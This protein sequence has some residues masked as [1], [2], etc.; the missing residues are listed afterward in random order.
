MPTCKL[1]TAPSL[2]FHVPSVHKSHFQEPLCLYLSLDFSTHNRILFIRYKNIFFRETKITVT[3]NLSR[4][5]AITQGLW[6][7]KELQMLES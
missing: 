6:S 5:V 1:I 7:H 3:N 4:G 2:H